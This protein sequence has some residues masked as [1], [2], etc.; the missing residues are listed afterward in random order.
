MLYPIITTSR[1]L[2]DLNGI[3]KVKLYHGTGFAEEWLRS[4]LQETI[5]M[6]VPVSFNDL[7]ERDEQ[8]REEEICL[9]RDSM[10]KRYS[11]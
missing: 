3:W 11:M 7:Y 9:R 10:C 6:P 8:H 2:V 1:E 4:P 5:P